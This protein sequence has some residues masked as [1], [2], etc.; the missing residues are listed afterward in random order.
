M[1]QYAGFLR[2][3]QETDDAMS[4]EEGERALR[5]YLAWGDRM[6][7]AG[8]PPSGGGLSRQGRVLAGGT[9]TNGPFTESK[10]VLGGYILVEAADLDEAEKIFADHPHLGYG[11]IE[12]RKVGTNGCEP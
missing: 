12:L 5:A 7:A 9:A 2:G 11:S 10:E 8:N 3:T 4:P 1:A 6:T